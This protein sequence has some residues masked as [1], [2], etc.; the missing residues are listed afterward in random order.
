MRQVTATNYLLTAL[1]VADMLTMASYLPYAVYFYCVTVLDP[2]ARHPRAWIVYLL[3]NNNFVITCHTA[4]MWLTVTLAVF[5]YIVVC[6]HVLGP[7]L[8]NIRRARIAVVA[9]SVATV[10]FCVPNYVQ[11]RPVA[12]NVTEGSE[13][14]Y[15]D[16]DGAADGGSPASTSTPT[17]AIAAE[18][19]WLKE[20]E[21]ITQ[22]YRTIN[23]WS[24]GVVLKVAPCVLLTVLSSLLVRAMRVADVKRRRLKS[25]G[26]GAES[27]KAGDHNRTTAMLVAVVLCF[28]VTE[29]PPGV[30]AFLSGIFHEI[31]TDVYV[32]LGDVWDIL[33]LVNS[34]VN[35]I[36]YCTMN[37]RF[38]ETFCDLFCGCWLAAKRRRRPLRS[39][40]TAANA[41]R[42]HQPMSAVETQ[43]SRL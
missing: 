14:D 1:A 26:R 11:H 4:A 16:G 41:K 5:R 39:T 31:F 17:A 28:V 6:H 8:C 32:P 10:V 43:F 30:I 21:F 29:L 33:V 40:G 19:Y 36:L 7:R 22:R 18:A 37:R 12:W 38:R 13:I 27:D 23:F 15:Y 35:F 42:L 3:F 20:N 24:Y 25:Q 9:V 34:A 2:A